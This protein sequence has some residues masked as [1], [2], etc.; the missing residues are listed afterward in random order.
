MAETVAP[1]RMPAMKLK[2]NPNSNLY[3]TNQIYLR[4]QRYNWR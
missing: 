2:N 4:N 3:D 1:E